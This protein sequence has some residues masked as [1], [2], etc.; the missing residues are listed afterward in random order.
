VKVTRKTF[1]KKLRTKGGGGGP[2]WPTLFLEELGGL[3]VL[4]ALDQKFLLMIAVAADGVDEASF[5]YSNNRVVNRRNKRMEPGFLEYIK[6]CGTLKDWMT[7]LT[8][9][10]AKR[11]AQH[12][13]Q[14]LED[15]MSDPA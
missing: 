3:D 7:D 2:L 14:S 11:K 1:Y 8:E 13:E 9:R 12:Q 6:V 10:V 5:F 15:I 4:T